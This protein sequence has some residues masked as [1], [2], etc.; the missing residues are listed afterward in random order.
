[1]GDSRTGRYIFIEL[2]DTNDIS[3]MQFFVWLML[4]V[5][6]RTFL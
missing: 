6:F 3:Q 4:Y 2:Q 1:M 5:P